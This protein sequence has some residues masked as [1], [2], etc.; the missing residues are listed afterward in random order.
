MFLA[1]FATTTTAISSNLGM[2]VLYFDSRDLLEINPYVVDEA[3][4]M[5][6]YT[7]ALVPI[8]LASPNK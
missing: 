8:M 4:L 7:T 1:R 2:G 6:A 3:C 5:T